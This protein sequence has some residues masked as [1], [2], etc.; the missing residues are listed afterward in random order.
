MTQKEMDAK[1]TRLSYIIMAVYT[2]LISV[3]QLYMWQA[4]LSDFNVSRKIMTMDMIVLLIIMVVGDLAIWLMFYPIKT[5]NNPGLS[6]QYLWFALLMLGSTSCSGIWWEHTQ[7]TAS[8]KHTYYSP[9]GHGSVTAR[10]QYIKP[11]NYKRY[12][13]DWKRE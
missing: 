11:I 1:M 6:K 5:K 10:S 12:A 9:D 7:D 2:L 3:V 13:Y 4:G 8:G